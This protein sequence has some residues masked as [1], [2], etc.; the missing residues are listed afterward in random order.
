VP[1]VNEGIHAKSATD[2]SIHLSIYYRINIYIY[3]NS[4]FFLPLLHSCRTI[5]CNLTSSRTCIRGG[6]FHQ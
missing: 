1:H 4:S 5:A 3:I 6:A 2:L